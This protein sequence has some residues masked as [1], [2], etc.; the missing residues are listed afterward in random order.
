MRSAEE[1][2]AATPFRTYCA[3]KQM[4][5]K[6][7]KKKSTRSSPEE[8][9]FAQPDEMPFRLE[10]PIQTALRAKLWRLGYTA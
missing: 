5:V 10:Q 2:I 9:K 4:T 3:G 8:K 1:P 7:P 6:R